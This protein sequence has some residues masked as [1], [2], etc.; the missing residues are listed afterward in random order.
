[1][2][3]TKSVPDALQLSMLENGLDFIHSGLRHISSPSSKFDLKYAVLHLSAG[4]E[5]VLKEWLRR[6]DWKLLFVYPNQAT[7]KNLR[8]G[9]FKSVNLDQCLALLEEH[10]PFQ[11]P[12]RA[13]LTIFK[14]QRNPIE[15][16]EM[17]HRRDVLEAVAAAV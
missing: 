2:A 17:N 6:E 15:H 13:L 4:I 12:D 3:P 16:F 9:V 8:S 7:L 10:C 5:L 1:M 14:N 11:L